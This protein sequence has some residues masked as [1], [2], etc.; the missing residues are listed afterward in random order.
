[1]RVGIDA[2]SLEG[3]RTGVGRYL[4]ALLLEWKKAAKNDVEFWLYFRNTVPN[5]IAHEPRFR[6]VVLPKVLG[7]TSN[8]LFVHCAIPRAFKR[9]RITVGFFPDYVA[10]FWLSVPYGLTLHDIVYAARPDLY[11]WPSVTDKLLLTAASRHAAKKANIIFSP[12]RFSKMEITKIWGIPQDRI[13]VTSEGAGEEFSPVPEPNDNAMR[14]QYGIQGQFILFIGSIF[15]RRNIPA[16]LGTFLEVAKRR[17]DLQFLLAGRNR[18]RPHV[19]IEILVSEINRRLGR[20]AVLRSPFI[21]HQDLPAILRQA[22][23]LVWISEY[24]GF[25]LP[26]LEALASGCP[27]ITSRMASLPEVAGDAA[28]YIEDP[29]DITSITQGMEKILTDNALAN[30]LRQKGLERAKEFSWGSCATATLNA[31]CS[32]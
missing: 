27:V 11:Y 17:P 12:S 29:K 7:R 8:A 19:D 2:R 25:G 22:A 16:C 15:T 26:V 6:A 20:P 14:I 24:E 31:L 18:T 13:I 1:M 30:N 3:E 28:L 9:D 21:A 23:A 4:S 32:L 5:D 10:P